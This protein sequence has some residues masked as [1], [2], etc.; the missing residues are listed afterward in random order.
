LAAVAVT[1][2]GGWSYILLDRTPSL[3]AVASRGGPR[4]DAVALGGLALGGAARRSAVARVLVA[5]AAA[6]IAGFRVQPPTAVQTV[7]APTNRTDPWADPKWLAPGFGGLGAGAR[8]P[9][10]ADRPC[11]AVALRAAV[12]P[13]GARPPAG[14]PGFRGRRGRFAAGRVRG[15]RREHQQRPGQ[16]PRIKR[17]VLRWVAA[18]MG[19][20]S[21]ATY[22]LATG[23]DPVMA[24]GGFTTTA[25][26]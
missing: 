23:G 9:S 7:A 8:V 13:P 16:G 22:E 20:T 2:T 19:S 4:R 14:H 21:A 6:L 1:V 11:S 15:G 10:A 25:A 18:T 3:A 17:T 12:R 5:L 26:S 24:I